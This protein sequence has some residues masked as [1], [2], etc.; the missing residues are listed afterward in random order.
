MQ[1]SS[2][3]SATEEV[4]GVNES[5]FSVPLKYTN[6]MTQGSEE[7]SNVMA[8]KGYKTISKKGK[9]GHKY[10]SSRSADKLD[11]IHGH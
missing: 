7:F 10:D 8:P 3:H 2:N 11:G 6:P 4:L 1:G 5:K 9:P